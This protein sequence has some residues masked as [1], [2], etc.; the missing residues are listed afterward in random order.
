MR[1]E[2]DK[3]EEKGR[4]EDERREGGQEEERYEVKGKTR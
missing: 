3:M 2:R 1:G 4:T